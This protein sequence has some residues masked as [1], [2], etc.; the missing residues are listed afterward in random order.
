MK[1]TRCVTAVLVFSVLACGCLETPGAAP[2]APQ[3]VEDRIDGIVASFEPGNPDSYNGVE[4]IVDL[5]KPAVPALIRMLS[6]ED[7]GR[8][9]AASYALSRLVYGMDE[10]ERRGLS[11]NLRASFDDPEPTVRQTVA[12]T[13]VAAGDKEGIPILIGYLR[14]DDMRLLSSPREG[15]GAYSI[16]VL[17]AYCGRDFGYDI[18]KPM[19][20]REAAIA[21][22]EGWWA[23]NKDRLAYDPGLG[24]YG[25]YSVR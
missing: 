18:H 11:A 1:H 20:E 14:S 6:D 3:P 13:A 10:A 19:G 2:R 16:R 9:W 23:A 7:V 25:G 24:D 17:S 21:G 15:M 4:G 8:R 22:W 5:G 12:G